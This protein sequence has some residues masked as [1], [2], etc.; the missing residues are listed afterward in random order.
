MMIYEVTGNAIK[1]AAVCV[2]PD[3]IHLRAARSCRW[4]SVDGEW[5]VNVDGKCARVDGRI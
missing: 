4:A 3:E 1:R 2:L 5:M